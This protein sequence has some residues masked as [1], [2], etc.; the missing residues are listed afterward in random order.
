[1]APVGADSGERSAPAAAKR[2]DRG[3]SKAPTLTTVVKGAHFDAGG[4][5][6][7]LIKGLGPQ[8]SGGRAGRGEREA[9]DHSGQTHPRSDQAAQSPGGPVRPVRR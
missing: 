4:G 9:L 5:G 6:Q 2:L 3:W 8:W 7:R 1:M